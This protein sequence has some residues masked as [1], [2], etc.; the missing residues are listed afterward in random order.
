MIRDR[1]KISGLIWITGLSGSGKT[2][3]AKLLKEKFLET[4]SYLP[5]M[6]D[7]DV[8]RKV[9]FSQNTYTPHERRK[10]SE[11]Y[12]ALAT[13]LVAQG[14]LVIC[15]T[16]SM[17][18]DVRNNNKNHNAHYCEVFLDVDDEVRKSRRDIK[19]LT[20]VDILNNNSLF[21][22]PQSP[23]FHLKNPK[24]SDVCTLCSDI[25]DHLEEAWKEK[26]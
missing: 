8:L 24:I 13:A 5:I 23:D 21:Q 20:K 1:T 2:T 16:I 10:L 11:S 25:L 19:S 18:Q 3:L 14:H 15:S 6:L 7:G 26:I 22:L 4:Y 9:L 17:F 12:S